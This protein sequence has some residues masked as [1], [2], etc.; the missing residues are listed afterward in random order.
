MPVSICINARGLIQKKDRTKVKQLSLLA[1][2]LNAVLVGVTE[3]WM[4]QSSEPGEVM[5][6]GFSIYR[7]DRNGRTHGGV[8]TYVRNDIPVAPVLSYSNGMVEIIIIKIPLWD[9]IHGVIYRPPNTTKSK[10][11]DAIHRMSESI[12]DCQKGGVYQN[13]ILEG[14]LN[15]PDGKWDENFE[16]FDIE[17]GNQFEKTK[18]FMSEF[19]MTQIVNVYTRHD[20]ILDVILTNNPELFSH[21]R[22]IINSVYSDH[23]FVISY[24]NIECMATKTEYKTSHL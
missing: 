12:Y 23:N 7:T 9:L 14:D 20:K 3:T 8:C 2:E 6:D 16:D 19:F 17:G 13:I 11:N 1:H 15:F 21:H 5:M 22:T 18:K 4:D 24:M 10:W